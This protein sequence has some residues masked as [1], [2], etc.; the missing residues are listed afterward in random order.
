MKP[1]LAPKRWLHRK[2]A[3]PHKKQILLAIV[4]PLLIVLGYR[5]VASAP[6]LIQWRIAG[7]HID[8]VV[9]FAS[10]GIGIWYLRSFGPMK[11]VV[12]APVFV[13]LLT[14]L[15]I[16]IPG[17]GAHFWNN[18]RLAK[19]AKQ[20]H[21]KEFEAKSLPSDTKILDSLTELTG[22]YMSNWC[23]FFTGVLLET[24][25]TFEEFK[26]YYPE[27]EIAW[28]ES[29]KLISPDEGGWR[30]WPRDCR[31]CVEPPGVKKMAELV[32]DKSTTE[33]ETFAIVYKFETDLP[34]FDLRCH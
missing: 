17:V 34:G 32:W 28:L 20:F 2:S 29:G 30:E 4:L 12:V 27:S 19:M 8:L 26:I 3:I 22:A 15:Y 11:L 14:F 24:K 10:F 23:W 16:A 18:G 13:I 6:G 9:V 7:I 25:R 21:E 33:G 31:T 1:L 5:L